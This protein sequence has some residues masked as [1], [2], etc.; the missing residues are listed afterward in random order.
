MKRVAVFG[1]NRL[2]YEAIKRL[3]AE[4]YQIIVIDH[5]PPHVA[6][7]R[8]NGFLTAEIDFRSDEDL[9]SIGVGSN[10]DALFCFFADDSENVFLTLSARALDKTLNII[11][12]VEDPESAQKLIAAG[13]NKIIDPFQICGRKIHE[14]IKRP[15]LT[16]IFDHTVFGRHDLNLAEIVI[17]PQ[18]YLENAMLNQLKLSERYNLILIGVVDKELGEQLHFA[19]GENDHRLNAGDILVI[20]GPSREIRAFKK[21]VAHVE[22]H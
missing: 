22:P 20:L 13:A 3:D 10:L 11:A 7:A 19:T 21:E 14:L 1:Y 18:S 12:V 15:D 9:K 16:D 2:S 4:T 6:S 8:E 5:H 17:P